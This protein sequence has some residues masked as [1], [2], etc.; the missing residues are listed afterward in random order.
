MTDLCQIQLAR[1]GG[2]TGA[3]Y[4]RREGAQLSN[5]LLHEQNVQQRITTKATLRFLK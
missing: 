5:S 4:G 1:D 2:G 3:G